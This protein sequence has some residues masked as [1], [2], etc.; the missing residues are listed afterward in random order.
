MLARLEGVK[1]SG[2]GYVARCPVHDDRHSSLSV[3][4]GRDRAV[5]FTCH[6]CSAQSDAIVI[7]LGLEPRDVLGARRD[8]DVV[9]FRRAGQA[10]SKRPA[11]VER[12]PWSVQGFVHVK[13]RYEDG[14]KSF[15]WQQRDGTRG[16]PEGVKADSLLY[17]A[18]LLADLPDGATVAVCEGEKAADAVRAV[19]LP[20]VATVTGAA[21]TPSDAVLS[22]LVRLDPVLWPDN[23][24]PGLGHMRRTAERMVTLGKAPRWVFWEGAPAKGDAADAPPEDRPRLIHEAV[25]YTPENHSSGTTHLMLADRGN[26]S[27]SEDGP[28]GDDP[29]H[30]A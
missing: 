11:V 1:P 2:S 29:I 22:Q 19:G 15:V 23:D 28:S 8:G 24:E 4:P 26:D 25:V 6:A 5:V 12:K 9:P 18:E 20:A 10:E 13:L 14:S 30:G 21:G 7:A 27:L 3:S 16:L 17:G